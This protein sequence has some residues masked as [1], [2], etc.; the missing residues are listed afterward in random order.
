MVPNNRGTP[1]AA[2]TTITRGALESGDRRR[3]AIC[4]P[5]GD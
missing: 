1:P 4:R 2:A 5:S 3:K